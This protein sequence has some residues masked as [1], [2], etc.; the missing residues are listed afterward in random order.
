[1][2][3][4][5]MPT[6]QELKARYAKLEGNERLHRIAHWKLPN[7]AKR[8]DDAEFLQF[9]DDMGP[10]YYEALDAAFAHF[11]GESIK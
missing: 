11:Q 5:L 4:R 7:C 1:M 6:D 8:F 3:N 9:L 10:H 2:A